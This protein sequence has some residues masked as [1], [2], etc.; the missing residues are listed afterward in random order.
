MVSSA[1]EP[2]M[3]GWT[4]VFSGNRLIPPVLRVSVGFRTEFS[5]LWRKSALPGPHLHITAVRLHAGVLHCLLAWT[6][7][8]LSLVCTAE[9]C[10]ACFSFAL[11]SPAWSAAA[12]SLWSRVARRSLRFGANLASSLHCRLFFKWCIGL[13]REKLSPWLFISFSNTK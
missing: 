9:L 7:Q 6:L 10:T 3:S 8:A 1:W 5:L 13:W 11:W 4:L 12:S 2:V